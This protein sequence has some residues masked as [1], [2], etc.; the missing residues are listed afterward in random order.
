[1]NPLPYSRKPNAARLN[2]PRALQHVID[3][4]CEQIAL[5]LENLG[6]ADATRVLLA[7]HERIANDLEALGNSADLTAQKGDTH[8]F[9]HQD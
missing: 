1:M 8:G 3:N 4:C 5:Q 6:T 2:H 7:I 9:H